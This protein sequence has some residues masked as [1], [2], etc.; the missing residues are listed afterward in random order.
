MKA[1][2]EIWF[3]LLPTDSALIT[4]QARHR[5][6]IGNRYHLLSLSLVLLVL[7]W[8]FQSSF[9]RNSTSI[10]AISDH[11]KNIEAQVTV[12]QQSVA[13][14]HSPM[15]IST[16]RQTLSY[17]SRAASA[18][19]ARSQGRAA[20]A[21]SPGCSIAREDIQSTEYSIARKSNKCAKCMENTVTRK[22]TQL[23]K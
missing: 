22:G 1:K 15:T 12:H 19:N 6:M 11:D 3:L 8:W 17:S 21:Q 13:I 10:H 5:Y 23:T 16:G 4:S 9:D 20:S 18:R 2:H 7:I 14:E